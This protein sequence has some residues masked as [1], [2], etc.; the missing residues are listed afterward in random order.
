MISSLSLYQ[1]NV[2]MGHPG[3]NRNGT[4][5]CPFVPG[6]RNFLVPVSLCPGTRAGAKIPG[7]TPLSLDFLK[8][9]FL[10][11]HSTGQNGTGCQNLVPSHPMSRPGFWQAVPAHHVPWQDIEFFSLSLC[12][13]TIK[14]LLLFICRKNLHCPVPFDTLVSSCNA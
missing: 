3:T 7:Q 14:E 4:S 13:D 6:Q 10:L 11:S 8:R 2:S 9:P 12:S 5:C 1:I